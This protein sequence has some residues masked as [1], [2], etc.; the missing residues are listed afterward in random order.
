MKFRRKV[1]PAREHGDV[2]PL[3]PPLRK[4]R[5]PSQATHPQ[6]A[7]AQA[8]LIA[9]VCLIAL[10]LSPSL[11]FAQEVPE[12]QINSRYYVVLDA[13]TGEIYA[14]RGAHELAPIASLTKIFTTIE[15]L[16]RAPLSTEITTTEFDYVPDDAST[17][18]FSAGETFSLEELL[19]GVMLPSG[20]DAAHAIART[21]GKTTEDSTDTEAFRQFVAWMNQR[22]QTMGLVNTHLVNPD[23]W[24]VPNHYSS[25]Y[26]LAAFTRYALQYP[27]FVEL[28]STQEYTTE[29]G[30]TLRNN[31]R[32][33]NLYPEI[34]GGKTG[35]DWDSGWCLIEVARRGDTTMISVTLDGIA[36]D[37]WYDDNAV[38]LDYAFEQKAEREK[39]GEQFVGDIV[40]FTDPGAA[41]LKQSVLFGGSGTG[42]QSVSQAIPTPN[43]TQNLQASPT[44]LAN[45]N[46]TAVAPVIST[47]NEESDHSGS[48]NWQIV[49]VALVAILVI[50]VRFVDSWCRNPAGVPWSIASRPTLVSQ[51]VSGQVSLDEDATEARDE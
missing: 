40:T 15:A 32:L 4:T 36:P 28:I 5:E 18:G 12:L 3:I 20:N 19:Y 39:S 14:Q 35:Y 17:M 46:P 21:L 26:D 6:L 2:C 47:T 7:R 16:E 34:I 8:R 48:S 31:N 38:L 24:G 44:V 51:D 41:L 9:V 27:M 29:N 37:D 42:Q 10:L 23:G 43:P 49:A 22:I 33:L 1:Q 30:Y 45:A 50:S 13:E 11:V 25:A